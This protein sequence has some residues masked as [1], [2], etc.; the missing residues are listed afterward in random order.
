MRDFR[1]ILP[2]FQAGQVERNLDLVER[3]RRI[4]SERGATVAQL[5][6]AWVL[7]RGDRIV[8]LLGARRRDRLTESLGALQVEL[9]ADDL[10]AIEEAV[11]KDG[12]L[13]D[14]YPGDQMAL[15]DSER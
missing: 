2:R 6:I 3:L 12:V 10:A 14:R 9:A 11:P 5:A 8:P 1:A 13:G 15:L 7:T 4:A